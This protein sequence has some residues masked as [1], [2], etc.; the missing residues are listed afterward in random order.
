VRFVQGIDYGPRKG[1][2]GFAVHM[3]EGGDGTLGYLA[4]RGTE[5]RSEWV[6]RVRGVSANFVILSTGEKVQ[7][8]GWANA[9]GSMNPRDR[10][11]T[12]GFYQTKYIQAVLGDKYTD[13]N[14]YSLSVEITGYRAAGPNAKQVEA[15]V[16]LVAESR[17]RFPSLRGAYGHADQTSTK[18]CPGTSALMREAW[19]RIGHGLF[20][21]D[22]G[23]E[24]AMRL[25]PRGTEQGRVTYTKDSHLWRVRDEA[26]VEV[27][28]G[29]DRR[30]YSAVD[31]AIKSDTTIERDGWLVTYDGEAH[32]APAGVVTF[33]P[34]E[35]SQPYPVSV[36][37]TVGDEKVQLG[38]KTVTL[39]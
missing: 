16:E 19:T 22:T 2:L 15:L 29:F 38:P 1:T 18:G 37:V 30:A 39:P 13:P 5:S 21:P 24:A 7:M 25:N 14:A 35:A 36:T 32:I 20:L 3:A 28:T 11:D 27:K 26:Q 34:D 17:Q 10:S 23:T 4:R 9:S 6:T 33:D 8:V 12:S 31:Y